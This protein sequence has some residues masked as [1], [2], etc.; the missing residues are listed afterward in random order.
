M[1]DTIIYTYK[2][3]NYQSITLYEIDYRRVGW[4]NNGEEHREVHRKVYRVLAGKTQDFTPLIMYQDFRG[5]WRL[6][7][8]TSEGDCNLQV[9]CKSGEPLEEE[10]REYTLSLLQRGF[11]IKRAALGYL[12]MG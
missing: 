2:G 11:S 1:E 6:D 5:N 7:C 4:V 12:Y 3:Y 10:I 8:A 9:F